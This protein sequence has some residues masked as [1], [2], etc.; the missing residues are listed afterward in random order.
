MDNF[1]L[2][3]IFVTDIDSKVLE[4]VDKGVLQVSLYGLEEGAF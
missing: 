4:R 3:A 2:V 1:V